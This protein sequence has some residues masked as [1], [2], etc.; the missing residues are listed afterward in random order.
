[1]SLF[2]ILLMTA[3]TSFL[4]LAAAPVAYAQTV[5]PDFSNFDEPAENTAKKSKTDTE[6]GPP[7]TTCGSELPKPKNQK[8]LEKVA[9]KALEQKK[10]AAKAEKPKRKQLDCVTCGE[11]IEPKNYPVGVVDTSWSHY[12]KIA[13]YSNS[14]QVAKMVEMAKKNQ[15]SSSHS[16][17]Y[18]W[19]KGALCGLDKKYLLGKATGRCSP[20]S[21]V[22]S[23]PAGSR[24]S[25]KNSSAIQTLKSHGFTNLLDNPE[26]RSLITNPAAAPKG[27]IMIYKGGN[28]GGHIE[29]K[30][31]VG[32][33]SDYISDFNAEN[34][35][36]QN[37]LG[38]RSSRRY[39][40][41]G[42]MVKEDL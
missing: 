8:D 30:T 35:I 38:G 34:S 23:Y 29:I 5:E 33:K 21:L 7:C 20:G 26:T 16:R 12:P 25:T 1:M 10:P 40:L 24:V 15:L 32:G 36:L 2:K 9:K 31:G 13:A 19:V 3:G 14:P 39:T 42:V 28:N 22:S 11:G 27:A 4:L 37:D 41:V 18:R 17:C 6:A